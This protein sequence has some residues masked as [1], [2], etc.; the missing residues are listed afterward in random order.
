MSGGILQQQLSPERILHMED[1]AYHH[2]ERLVGVWQGQ[3]VRKVN[4]IDGA[5]GQVIR[6]EV[7]LQMLDQLPQLSEVPAFRQAQLLQRLSRISR[8]PGNSC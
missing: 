2:F 5:P 6:N 8:S 1:I 7:R 3:K 4:A